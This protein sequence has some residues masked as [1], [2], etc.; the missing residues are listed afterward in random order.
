MPDHEAALRKLSLNDQAFIESAIS[1]DPDKVE[2][3]NLD[4][5][6]HALVRLGALVALDAAPAS[7]QWNVGIALAAG[8][9]L[10][11]IV[12]VLIAVAPAVGLARTVSAAPELALAIGYDID[13][14]LAGTKKWRDRVD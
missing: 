10:E 4:P 5:K 2:G 9:S 13:G 6:T 14:A 7:Y 3:S 8:A 12:G 1:I 11:E